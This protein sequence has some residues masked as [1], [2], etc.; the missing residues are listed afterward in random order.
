M[1]ATTFVSTLVLGALLG[2]SP[3]VAAPGTAKADGTDVNAWPVLVGRRDEAAKATG[4]E[5][6][7]PLLFE[8]RADNGAVTKGFRPFWFNRDTPKGGETAVLYPFFTY[9]YNGDR[10][11][12]SIL[13]LFNRSSPTK[14]GEDGEPQAFDLWPFYFSRDTGSPSTSYHAVFPLYGQV[15]NRFLNDR[16]DWVLFPLYGR[17]KKGRKVVTTAPW[18]FVR[19]ISGEGHHGWAL[20]PIAGSREDGGVSRSE[21][22]L[23]PLLYKYETGLDEPVPTVNEGFLPFYAS[24]RGPGLRSDIY[25][26]PFFGT[27][28]RTGAKAYH[29][30][31]YF[32]PFLVQGRG[33]HRYRNRWAPFYTHSMISGMDKTWVLWPLWKQQRWTEA[34][35]DQTRTEVL[36]F[37][38]WSL[39]EQR[40]GSPPGAPAAEKT[41]L[42]PLF[43]TWNNGAG[44]KQ[45]QVL[46]PLE[47]LFRYNQEV[48]TE[49]SPLFALFR[50][51]QRAPGEVRYSLLWDAL[52]YENDR[53]AH[54]SVFHLGPLY[55]AKRTSGSRRY[56]LLDGLISLSKT[57][58]TG[59]RLRFADFGGKP[60]PGISKP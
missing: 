25:L 11:R 13:N 34:G 26:W 18:P 47:P 39:R 41:H 60:K 22:A 5:A 2:A 27:L 54:R 56:A 37:L 24:Q 36:F 51:D 1:N 17:F 48:R 46:S 50:Y 55:E 21:Y 43:S 31:R 3:V 59:W 38:Y 32:W 30:T 9:R 16:V 40:A 8:T 23:W 4:W 28:D 42:W 15:K 12:W 19:V 29:E 57:T 10:W 49:Y 7:G 52:S 6:A 20:W 45:V 53:A 44:R 14:P 58:G 35:L 33:T